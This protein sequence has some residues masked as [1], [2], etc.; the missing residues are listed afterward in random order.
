MLTLQIYFLAKTNKR[1][2]PNQVEEKKLKSKTK[3]T[4]S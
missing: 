3:A 2:F 4:W 1:N